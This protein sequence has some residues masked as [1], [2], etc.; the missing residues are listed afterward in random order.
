[1]HTSH[2][3]LF[4]VQLA[5]TSHTYVCLHIS[6]MFVFCPTC[7]HISHLCL[8]ISSCSIC[9]LFRYAHFSLEDAAKTGT[10][11]MIMQYGTTEDECSWKGNSIQYVT[12]CIDE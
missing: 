8:F 1:M 3:C 7:F 4:S 11:L 5:S 2:L 9:L 6:P 12:T 10:T